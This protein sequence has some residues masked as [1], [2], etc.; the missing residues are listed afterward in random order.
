MEQFEII[1]KQAY[2]LF[3]GQG[4]KPTH[5]LTNEKISEL[6]S[7]EADCEKTLLAKPIFVI[8]QND[9]HCVVYEG[10]NLSIEKRHETFNTCI[11]I[12]RRDI[13]RSLNS[14][15]YYDEP[16]GTTTVVW[17][18]T[19]KDIQKIR[20]RKTR[21]R[22]KKISAPNELPQVMS[23]MGNKYDRDREFM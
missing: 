15:Y 3:K 1:L 19:Q 6:L 9:R 7:I 23:D 21:S 8:M 4:H 12:R 17:A 10:G 22:T 14:I 5:R 16:P 2:A 20:P 18:A 11:P 13:S